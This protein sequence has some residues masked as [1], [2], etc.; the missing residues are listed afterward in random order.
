MVVISKA[1]SYETLEY[2]TI[3][4]I[5]HA[6]MVLPFW[7]H[8][9]SQCQKSSYHTLLARSSYILSANY[10]NALVLFF[11]IC[12]LGWLLTIV[13]HPNYTRQSFDLSCNNSQVMPN[14]QLVIC[15]LIT[16]ISVVNVVNVKLQ[17]IPDPE[18]KSEKIWCFYS[19]ST[20]SPWS[21]SS[22]QILRA[23][24]ISHSPNWSPLTCPSLTNSN[25]V[26]PICSNQKPKK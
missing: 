26:Y 13:C 24:H 20:L 5:K 12:L 25:T 8:L 7:C 4:R 3:W 19:V 16:G 21:S 10:I 9:P 23:M 22:W 17:S 15:L 2:A 14:R 11:L 6:C 1:A 18:W